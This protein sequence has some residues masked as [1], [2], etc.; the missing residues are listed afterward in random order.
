MVKSQHVAECCLTFH[1]K[2]ATRTPQMARMQIAS[3][4]CF[5]SFVYNYSTGDNRSLNAGK[6]LCMCVLGKGAWGLNLGLSLYHVGKDVIQRYVILRFIS[7]LFA[8]SPLCVAIISLVINTELQ[9]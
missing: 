2:R 5:D 7:P 4:T 3:S 6:C 9:K 1:G 8:I